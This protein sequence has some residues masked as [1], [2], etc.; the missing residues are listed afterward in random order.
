MQNVEGEVMKKRSAAISL[1]LALLM[2]MFSS[3]AVLAEGDDNGADAH[4]ESMSQAEEEVADDEPVSM[5]EVV[6][7][8]VMQYAPYAA[9]VL[10]GIVV[11]VLVVKIIRNIAGRAR[12][13]KYTGRH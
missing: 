8:A 1:I 13:P 4:S 9:G 7:D 6:K 12:K 11:I 3:A 5:T 10:G 2:L